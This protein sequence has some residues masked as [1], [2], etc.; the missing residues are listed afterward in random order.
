MKLKSKLFSRLFI[1][2]WL[3][4]I[5][6][7]GCI[8]WS[9]KFD[10]LAEVKEAKFKAVEKQISSID[11]KEIRTDVVISIARQTFESPRDTAK[12]LLSLSEFLLFVSFINLACVWKYIKQ[13]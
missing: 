2:A 3:S 4:L 12:I 6:G 5:L 7:A 8:Y 9:F 1:P 11:C 13:A 10:S